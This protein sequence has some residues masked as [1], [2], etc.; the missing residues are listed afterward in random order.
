MAL[1]QRPAPAWQPPH[2]RLK[3]AV[4]GAA[5]LHQA[6]HAALPHL[7]DAV[8]ADADPAGRQEAEHAGL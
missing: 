1:P 7:A 5:A 2:Q 8:A 4:Q 6:L 3:G